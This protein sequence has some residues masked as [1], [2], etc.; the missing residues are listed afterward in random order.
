[1]KERERKERAEQREQATNDLMSVDPL[2]LKREF[3]EIASLLAT[4]NEQYAEALRKHLKAKRRK[5]ETY[6]RL[7]VEKRE[8]AE[9]RL[10]G[11]M[12]KHMV[13]MDEEFERASQIAI[14]AEVGKARAFG[15]CEA[16]RAKKDALISLGAHVRA[17]LAGDPQ[18]REY[19]RAQDSE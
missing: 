10:T 12:L 4:A 2:H 8:T 9:E 19:Q 17:E 7:Y 18:L 15:K 3:T 1:M 13:E 6:A 11:D 14:D 16:L 5:D